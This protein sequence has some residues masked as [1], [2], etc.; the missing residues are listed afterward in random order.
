METVITEEQIINQYLEHLKE[1][2]FPCVAARAALSLSQV[3]CMVASHMAC[4]KD[5]GEIVRFLYRFIAAYRATGTN[6]H[7]AA[8]IFRG[9]EVPDESMFD[10]LLWQ[11]LQALA[12]ID[13]T[14]CAYDTRVSADPASA[15]FSFSIGE[16][17]FYIIGLHPQSSRRAR[18]VPYPV[19]VF[20]PHAQFEEL[21]ATA[22]YDRM[23]KTVRK[24]DLD[25]SGSV[26]PMLEDFGASSE[27]FQYSGRQYDAS[28]KCPL[29][30]N[31]ATTPNNSA[32]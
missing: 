23:K 32:S 7:S 30:I 26:N 3:D 5:D 4:P 14:Q 29:K 19:L 22:R 1:K 2:E 20:N 10:A 13:A 9:P 27:V 18:Q 6:F 28:W 21:R 11:R 31:H 15:S 25:Y 17:G 16:E 24:R 8:V 12:D